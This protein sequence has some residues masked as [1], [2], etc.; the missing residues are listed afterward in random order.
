MAVIGSTRSSQPDRSD[1]RISGTDGIGEQDKD[2]RRNDRT[3]HAD[4][5]RVRTHVSQG[6][7]LLAPGR[8]LRPGA[9]LPHLLKQRPSSPESSC[10]YR[11]LQWGVPEC[12]PRLSRR[13]CACRSAAGRGAVSRGAVPYGNVDITPPQ[14]LTAPV[15]S[16]VTA[17]TTRAGAT[18]TWATDEPSTIKVRYRRTKTT[19]WTSMSDAALTSTHSIGIAGLASRTGHQYRVTSAEANGNSATSA[20]ASFKTR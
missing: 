4:E 18:V 6:I 19:T 11:A 20:I 7:P 3:Y 10:D 12:S 16:A 8:V 15:I 2:D 9:I 5:K 17:S 13:D 14:D 1:V